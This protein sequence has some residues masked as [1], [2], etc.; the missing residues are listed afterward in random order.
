MVVNILGL[1]YPGLEEA[2][3]PYDNLLYQLADANDIPLRAYSIWFEGENF[4]AGKLAL[5]GIDTG[6]FS[7]S[8]Q[9]VTITPPAHEQDRQYV[10]VDISDVYTK[11]NGT[12]LPIASSSSTSIISSNG[13]YMYVPRDV[14]TTLK[15]LLD[16]SYDD[17]SG[18]M[19]Q[20]YADMK[21]GSTL[22]FNFS[23]A[24]IDVPVQ[25][26]AQP[27]N[28]THC[29]Y[30]ITLIPDGYPADYI[31]G[32][33][34]L[35]S[36]YVVFDYDHNQISF[37]Q[38]VHN[39]AS[40]VTAISASGV[41]G[42]QGTFTTAAPPSNSSSPAPTASSTAKASH[43]GMSSAT[44]IGIGVG[45]GVGVPLLILIAGLLFWTR[46]R[47]KQSKRTGPLEI[48]PAQPERQPERQSELP[49]ATNQHF[50]PTPVYEEKSLNDKYSSRTTTELPSSPPQ[51]YGSPIN[52]RF[53]GGT[54][55]EGPLSEYYESEATTQHG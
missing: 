52:K 35:R 46:R 34:F 47:S 49:S 13:D 15:T 16:V 10:L 20:T 6:K 17:A 51:H 50:E 44:K 5:G 53:S 37:Q 38:T 14:I 45:V 23:G 43:S 11:S 26:L 25:Q 55:K 28:A 4:E 2:T 54:F 12:T 18:T 1:G 33:S 30:E 32:V 29:Y 24:T 27:I 39:N 19:Y 21:N 40:N 22:G 8:L 7:G 9:T 3:T 36:A 42:L 31:L 48:D 41:A